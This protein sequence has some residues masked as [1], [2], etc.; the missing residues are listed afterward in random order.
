MSNIKENKFVKQIPNLLTISRIIIAVVIM[1]IE[2]YSVAFYVIYAFCGVSDSIDGTLARALKTSGR[3]GE[4]LDTIGDALLTYTTTHMVAMYA[5]TV[6]HLSCW[7][8]MVIAICLV[9]ASRVFGALVTLIR[10]K[11]FALL[12]TIGN[13]VGMFIFY[14]YPFMYK[15]LRD[16][17][18][19]GYGL[20]AICAL[21]VLAGIEEAIIE[22]LIP[23]FDPNVK[24]LVDVIKRRRALKLTPDDSGTPTEAQDDCDKR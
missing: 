16:V 6:D 7:Q 4:T 18:G 21:C 23:S 11:K 12:H 13:K 24:S 15:A 10:F 2:P 8:G 20:Y 14:L 3:L 9:F 17:G 5:R 1:F 19:A 22:L